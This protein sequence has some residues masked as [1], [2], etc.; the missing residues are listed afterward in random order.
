MKPMKEP[1]KSETNWPNEPDNRIFSGHSNYK[2]SMQ[3]G[4]LQKS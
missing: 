2:K 3:P 1:A 4:W